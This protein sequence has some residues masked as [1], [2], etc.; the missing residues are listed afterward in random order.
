MSPV[1][2]GQVKV[3]MKLKIVLAALGASLSVVSIAAEP[4]V[5]H[6]DPGCG[7][8]A[9][10]A[11][12]VRQHFG[13]R[14]NMIYDRGRPSFPPVPGVPARLSSFPPPIVVGHR[15]SVVVGTRLFLCF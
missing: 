1:P 11:A 10:W 15:T 6:R 12:Q 2:R 7:C 13:R 14:V 8:C 9:Q 5:V 3:D 4:I